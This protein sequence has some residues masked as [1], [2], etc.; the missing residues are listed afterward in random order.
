[1]A[2]KYLLPIKLVTK[3]AR[4][5][6]GL[7]ELQ[8]MLRRS[9]RFTHPDG[10]RRFH[11]WLFNIE[12]R[13]VISIKRLQPEQEDVYEPH[14]KCEYCKDTKRISVFDPC[15]RCDGEGC[16]SCDEGLVPSTIPCESCAPLKTEK[17]RKFRY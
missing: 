7:P 10:N 12:G 2:A 1:M 5:G 16:Q 4:D 11:D 9:A 6:V 15:P 14:Y 3:A 13:K 17:A 8:D